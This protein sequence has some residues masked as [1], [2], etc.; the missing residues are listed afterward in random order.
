MVGFHRLTSGRIIPSISGKGQGF[1][2]I[3]PLPTFCPF[4]VDL[5]TVMAPV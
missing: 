4:M 2:G 3:R 5:K 1:P